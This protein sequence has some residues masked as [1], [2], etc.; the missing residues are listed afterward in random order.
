MLRPL[1]NHGSDGMGHYGCP[2]MMMMIVMYVS[3]FG[4]WI[5]AFLSG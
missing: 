5:S 3:I 4:Q 1:P 2:I